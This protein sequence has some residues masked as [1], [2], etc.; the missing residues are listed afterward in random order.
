MK[1]AW[2]ITGFLVLLGG[3][4]LFS[5]VAMG[6]DK[7]V[8]YMAFC[9]CICIVIAMAGYLVEWFESLD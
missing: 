4:Y 5:R 9:L 8:G 6:P 7:T 3:L 2:Q 1:K